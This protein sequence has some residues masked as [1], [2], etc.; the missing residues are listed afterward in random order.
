VTSL[1][2]ITVTG[3][4]SSENRVFARLLSERADRYRALVVVHDA[5]GADAGVADQFAELA[6]S[7]T[8]P[9]DTGWRQNQQAYRGNP[10]RASV[11]LRYRQRLDRIIAA[12]DRFGPSAVYS[13]QQHYDCRAASKVARSLAIPQILHLHYNIGPWLRRVVLQQLRTT[14]RVVAVSDFIRWQAI[15]HGVPEHRVTTIHNTMPTYV[16]PDLGSTQALRRELGL[17]D[18][19]YVF[20]LVGRFDPGKGHL[21]AVAAFEKVA[22]RRDDAVLVLVGTGRIE[23]KILTRVRSSPVA[24]RIVITGQRSDVPALL[25]VFDAL[26]HPASQDPCPLAVLEAMA[27]A[28]PVVAYADG[29]VP[30]LVE[31]GTT[32]LLVGHGEVDALAEAMFAL[33]DDVAMGHKLGTAGAR[34]VASVFSP[35]TAGA[36]FADL[37]TSIS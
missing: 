28:L 5:G 23:G 15:N 2:G 16:R 6:K 35:A 22:R 27:A 34:R 30:E 3:G 31:G 1:L 32:G 10:F 21:D 12:A 17:A 9:L 24:D 18:D 4:L 26:V 19:Q 8:V 13:S 14:D 20:G 37:V 11:A 7:P 36:R 33:H 29:G 25:S